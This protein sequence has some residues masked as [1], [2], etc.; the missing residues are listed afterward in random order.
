[1][2]L[3]YCWLPATDLCLQLYS[4]GLSLPHTVVLRNKH[5]PEQDSNTATVYAYNGD[6]TLLSVTDARGASA[7]YAYNNRNLITNISHTVPQNSSIA[8]P[9]A[10]N[11][12]N[13]LGISGSRIARTVRGQRAFDGSTSTITAGNAGLLPATDPRA[14]QTVSHLLATD[15]RSP[16]AAQAGYARA[17]TG[18][19]L[20]DV[21]YKPE[22]FF[23]ESQIL[24]ESLHTFLGANLSDTDMKKIG[25]DQTS[26]GNAGC[27]STVKSYK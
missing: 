27:N 17:S 14:N 12:L 10:T 26:L 21:C 9:L 16:T 24:H 6:D 25:A 3:S 11:F 18:A 1:M 22:Y 15:P 13:K 19:S 23:F 4:E 5:L 7:I 20:N 8:L 2:S